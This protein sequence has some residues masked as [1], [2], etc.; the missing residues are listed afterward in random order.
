MQTLHVCRM[1]TQLN[2]KQVMKQRFFKIRNLLQEA[3]CQFAADITIAVVN[4]I[5]RSFCEGIFIYNV[6]DH[7][8]HNYKIFPF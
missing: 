6:Y 1:R 5:P 2:Q 8:E 7:N 4:L 3:N